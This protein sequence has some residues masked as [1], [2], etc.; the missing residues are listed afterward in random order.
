MKSD[1]AALARSLDEL[2]AGLTTIDSVETLTS[3]LA[4]TLAAARD[5]LQVDCVGL[6]LLDD[7]GRL[8]TVATTGPAADS[9]QQA[10]QRLGSGPGPDAIHA[11]ASVAADD[12][13]ALPGYSSLWGLMADVAV[14]A[15]VCSP[16]R[17]AG[18][19]V[20]ELTVTRPESHRWE[21]GEIAAI[22][23]FAEVTGALLA[24]FARSAPPTLLD[25][26]ARP[27][28]PAGRSPVAASDTDGGAPE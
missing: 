2:T 5:V 21:P 27:P 11:G 24:L 12:L 26:A 6:L 4:V 20:G 17:S 23:A 28:D 10:E 18:E 13:S 16:V 15:V 22:E 1:A 14:R 3:R 9:L 8:Q 19:V 25:L 7:G